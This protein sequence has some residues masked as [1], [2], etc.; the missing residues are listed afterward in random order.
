MAFQVNWGAAAWL[1]A[2]YIQN[3]QTEPPQ[4]S[5]LMLTRSFPQVPRY[6]LEVAVHKRSDGTFF[7]LFFENSFSI[8]HVH[9]FSQNTNQAIFHPVAPLRHKL[10]SGKHELWARGDTPR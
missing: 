1:P 9:L 4:P 8:V 10:K 5:N 3:A 2:V 7:G 6:L